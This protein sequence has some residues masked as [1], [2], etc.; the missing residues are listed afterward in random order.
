MVYEKTES[1]FR[2][3]FLLACLQLLY[4]PKVSDLS[5]KKMI[6][7][8]RVSLSRDLDKGFTIYRDA[9]ECVTPPLSFNGSCERKGTKW[10]SLLLIIALE[11]AVL[12]IHKAK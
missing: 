8:F 6:A 2:H 9:I 4:L 1:C 11:R 7:S 10:R 5:R 3:F 12:I